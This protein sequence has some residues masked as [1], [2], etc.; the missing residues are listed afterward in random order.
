MVCK[1]L[2]FDYR[3]SEKKFFE[4]NKYENFDIKFFKESLNEET[5]NKLNQE[6]LE[7]TLAISVF[8]TSLIT[9]EI[10]DKFKNLRIISTRSTGYN[11]IALEPCV[12]K[13]IALINVESYGSSSVA[14]FTFTII[15]MLIRQILPAVEA[16][17]SGTCV[18]KNFTGRNL[19]TL[20][21]GVIGTGAIGARVAQI[22]NNF[23]MKILAYDVIPKKE[24]EQKYNVQYVKLEELLKK[25]DIISL[26]VPANKET[27]HIIGDKQLKMMKDNS[28]LIN[29][30][31]G[32]LI[33][34]NDLLKFVKIG[35][36]NGVGLDVVACVNSGCLE[37]SDKLERDTLACLEESSVVK[38]LNKYPNVI[39]T[40]HTA[41]DTEESVDYILKT[42]FAGLTDFLCG[43]NKYRVL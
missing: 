38:E 27:Y 26:H 43:G 20:T 6:D 31:R 34:L 41:Y 14:E 28:Y 3:D 13:N 21:L 36:L 16:I 37:N 1:M 33:K 35:K 2:L 42:T 40:P 17:K 9:P 25:S 23:G 39:I 15:L 5:L 11:H 4:T 32:E 12:E 8:T 22:A 24:L 7:K 29:V 19:N 18:Q 30:S 10:I